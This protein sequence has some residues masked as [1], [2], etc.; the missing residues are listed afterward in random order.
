ML[1]MQVPPGAILALQLTPFCVIKAVYP[2]NEVND[3][4][5]LLAWRCSSQSVHCWT[6]RCVSVIQSQLFTMTSPLLLEQGF[7]AITAE[8]TRLPALQ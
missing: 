7:F 2:V 4:L 1:H 3:T 6:V 5:P 8:V